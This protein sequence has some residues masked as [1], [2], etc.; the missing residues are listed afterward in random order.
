MNDA[1]ELAYLAGIIDADG[2]ITI[3]ICKW[4]AT[5]GRSPIFSEMV[6]IGQCDTQA[7]EML[8]KRFGGNLR[9][10]K[11]RGSDNCRPFYLWVVTN[12]TAVTVAKALLPYL[13]IKKRHALLLLKLREIKERGREA[14]TYLE[15]PPV[16][17]KTR[18]GMRP[19]RRRFLTSE[20]LAEMNA[21]TSEIRTIND[22]RYGRITHMLPDG[23]T[24]EIIAG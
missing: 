4:R 23:K 21:L 16:L 5:I 8:Q 18:W 17:R 19:Y 3:A 9:L 7:L 14:N 10:Q 24:I 12:R 6:A 13:R 1:L 2:S 11:K 20:V 22:T 15:D